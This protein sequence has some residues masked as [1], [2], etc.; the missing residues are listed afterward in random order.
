MPKRMP[1]VNF[2]WV[3]GGNLKDNVFKEVEIHGFPR[4]MHVI[5]Y[6]SIKNDP[7]YATDGD[8]SRYP[9]PEVQSDWDYELEQSRE[10]KMK[11]IFH[12]EE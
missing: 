9:E 12:S 3:C 4:I 8:R 1:R 5:C 6:G 7:F 10:L 2:C 11:G